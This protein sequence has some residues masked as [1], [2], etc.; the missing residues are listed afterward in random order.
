MKNSEGR[1]NVF[2]QRITVCDC[3]HY[4]IS[5]FTRLFALNIYSKPCAFPAQLYIVLVNIF[6]W[7]SLT[8]PLHHHCLSLSVVVVDL[9]PNIFLASHREKNVPSCTHTFALP[10]RRRVSK[11]KKSYYE[12]CMENDRLGT[13]FFFCFV[14]Y[15]SLIYLGNRQLTAPELYNIIQT[16]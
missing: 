9:L 2:T 12:K 3:D 1:T 7:L 10:P 13:F 8:L 16:K 14:N 11:G 5:T 6:V 4:S 15:L